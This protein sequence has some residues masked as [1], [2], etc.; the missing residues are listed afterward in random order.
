MIAEAFVGAIH[1][2]PWAE[3]GGV[4][5]NLMR[6]QMREEPIVHLGQQGHVRHGRSLIG[7]ACRLANT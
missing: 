5:V 1:L 7:F 4:D 3:D 6:S 2:E